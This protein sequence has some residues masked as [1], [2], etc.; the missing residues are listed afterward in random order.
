MHLVMIHDR[1]RFG[2]RL[3]PAIAE[4][5]RR[6][7][8]QPLQR[9]AR[10]LSPRLE[11]VGRRFHLS[12]EEQPLLIRCGDMPFDRRVWRHLAGECLLYAAE[13]TCE[14]PIVEE[15]LA[16]FVPPKFVAR[17][18]RGSREIT[19]A[20]VP[21]RPHAAGLHDSADLAAIVAELRL[22]DCLAWTE[23]PLAD[24]PPDERTDELALA[25]QGFDELRRLLESAC[26]RDSLIVCEEI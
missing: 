3:A 22:F 17:L 6:R 11:Q 15:L 4:S 8:F 21:Y 13:E 25:R 12:A 19:F 24:V 5:F 10:E 14:F 26:E 16:R 9:L 18:I 23:A 7:T 2:A 20:G 1:E